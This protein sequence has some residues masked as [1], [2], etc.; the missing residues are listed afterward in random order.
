MEI[1]VTDPITGG[2]K[3]TKLARF[4][5]V[6]PDALWA[7]AEH[8]GKGS[9]KYADRNWEKGIVFHR[10]FRAMLSHAWKWW[11]GEEYDPEDDQHHLDAVAWNAFALRTYIARNM[12]HLDDRPK[13]G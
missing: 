9:Q 3:G 5:L 10:I 11:G 7:L 8:Y 4:S 13:K 1:R 12:T 2:Q 6:P